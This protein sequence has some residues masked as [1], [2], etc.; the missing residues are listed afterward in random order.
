[1]SKM[2]FFVLHFNFFISLATDVDV[3]LLCEEFIC[4][5][6]RIKNINLKL[7]YSFTLFL[8]LMNLLWH[9]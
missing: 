7:I 5:V 3:G 8:T 4:V 2:H 1:M 6:L 9:D